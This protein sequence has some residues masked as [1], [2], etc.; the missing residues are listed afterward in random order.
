MGDITP[1]LG[2]LIRELVIQ[3]QI[4][5][6]FEKRAKEVK[7]KIDELETQIIHEMADR[8]LEKAGC[9]GTTVEPLR[10]VYPHVEDWAV[11]GDFILENRYLHLLERRPTVTGYRELLL[12]GRDVPG[13]VPFTKIKL[14]VR[15]S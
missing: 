4:H 11:F 15:S 3:K 12:L 2:H 5:A 6:N 7:V 1:E 13:V 14:S 9:D 8:Q 10:A